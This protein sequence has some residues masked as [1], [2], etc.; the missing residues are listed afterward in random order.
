MAAR[1]VIY[2]PTKTATQS[3]RAKTRRWLLEF[4][5]TSARGP[6]SL[7]GWTFAGDC[8][9]QVRLSFPSQEKAIDFAKRHK[10]T[11]TL[12]PCAT[13]RITPRNYSDRFRAP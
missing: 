6:E 13:R 2:Q 1:A 10:M 9:N 12:I 8:T 7:M 5:P 4:L 11:Y 3:G